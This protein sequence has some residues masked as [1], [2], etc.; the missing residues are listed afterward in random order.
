VGTQLR[1]A[2]PGM[3][4]LTSKNFHKTLG[5]RGSYTLCR[6]STEDRPGLC[7]VLLPELSVAQGVR[8]SDVNRLKTFNV[9]QGFYSKTGRCLAVGGCGVR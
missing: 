4:A 5:G 7:D 8:A 2:G 1:G 6:S 9:S 3:L